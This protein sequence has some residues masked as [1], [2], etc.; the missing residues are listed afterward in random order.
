MKSLKERLQEDMKQA[1][2]D[3]EKDKLTTIRMVIADLKKQEIDTRQALTSEQEMAILTKLIKQRKES[4]EI[5]K[6]AERNDLAE[7]EQFEVNVL[8][9]YLPQQL[10]EHEVKTLIREAIVTAGAHSAK[11]MGKVMGLLRPQLAGRAD[12]AVVNTLVKAAFPS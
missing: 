4:Y 11:D 6:N 8:Q 12:M 7:R 3:Q 2:R 5:Y 1:M 9:H 10:S